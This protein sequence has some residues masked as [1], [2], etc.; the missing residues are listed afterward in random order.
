MNNTRFKQKV[1]NLHNAV[2]RIR[3]KVA[4]LLTE[5]PFDNRLTTSRQLEILEVQDLLIKVSGKLDDILGLK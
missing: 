2:N 4:E 5:L 1:N 3:D